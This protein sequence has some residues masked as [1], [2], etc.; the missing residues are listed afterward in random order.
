MPKKLAD[1]KN[2]GRKQSVSGSAKKQKAKHFSPK[3]DQ[4]SA[5][6]KRTGSPA[7]IKINA[8]VMNQQIRSSSREG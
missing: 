8:G 1:G 5:E 6:K 4:G 3:K 7:R 2:V